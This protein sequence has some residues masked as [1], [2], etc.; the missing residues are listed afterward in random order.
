MPNVAV[1]VT[2]FV[3]RQLVGAFPWGDAPGQLPYTVTDMGGES[4]VAVSQILPVSRAIIWLQ[5]PQSGRVFSCELKRTWCTEIDLITAAPELDKL[6]VYSF[7]MAR[8]KDDQ[9]VLVVGGSVRDGGGFRYFLV[10]FSPSGE[11]LRVHNA[12]VLS[13]RGDPPEDL[14]IAPNGN[15][16]VLRKGG[17]TVLGQDGAMRTELHQPGKLTP[18]GWYVSAGEEPRLYDQNGI[19]L[20][21]LTVMKREEPFSFLAAGAGNILI[22]DGSVVEAHE[23]LVAQVTMYDVLTLIPEERRLELHDRVL[24]PATTFY[25]TDNTEEDAAPVRSYFPQEGISFDS[26]GNLYQLEHTTTHCLVYV[27]PRLNVD[28]AS[29][30]KKFINPDDL[31]AAELAYAKAEYLTRAGLNARAGPLAELFT[32]MKWF[33]YSASFQDSALAS[34]RDT[35]F[36]R[37]DPR[38]AKRR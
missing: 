14:A 23:K 32:P 16:W 30:R 20:G 10:W 4:A 15:L 24:A 7:A 18:D 8:T 36:L 11:P 29:W 22:I 2:A 17:A 25:T 35:V 5:D 6:H 13:A 34:D 9:V 38:K 21:P 1:V 31:N 28:S 19:D 26:T 37:L 3:L 12:T 33:E 27:L